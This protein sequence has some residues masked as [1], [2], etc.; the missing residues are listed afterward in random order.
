MWI[1]I[2]NQNFNLE[3]KIEK[4]YFLL[5]GQTHKD[6]YQ[7]K[8]KGVILRNLAGGLVLIIYSI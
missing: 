8:N 7:I 5:S 3:K 1:K 6:V 2:N 4:Y